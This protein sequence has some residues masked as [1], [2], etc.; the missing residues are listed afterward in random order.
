MRLGCV[1]ARTAASQGRVNFIVLKKPI[2]PAHPFISANRR[3]LGRSNDP[4][5]SP[6]LATHHPS[7]RGSGN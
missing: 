3:P 6:A 5:E 7:V 2:H 1:P 4:M